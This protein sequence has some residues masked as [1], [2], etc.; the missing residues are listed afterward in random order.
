MLPSRLALALAL[1]PCVACNALVGIPGNETEARD[2]GTDTTSPGMIVFP[3]HDAATDRPSP[4]DG[5]SDAGKPSGAAVFVSS[6]SS[7]QNWC[8]VTAGGDVY[9]WGDNEAGQLGTSTGIAST[10]PVKITG[11]LEPAAQVSV[12]YFT[13]CALTTTGS[14]YCWGYGGD[15]ELGN[16]STTN[17]TATPVP[18]S[19]LTSGVVALS[20]GDLDACAIKEDGSVWCW[21]LGPGGV[22]GNGTMNDSLAPTEVVGLTGGATSVSVGVDAACAVVHGGVMC[23]GGES[24]YGDLGNGTLDES[25]TP[26]QVTGLTSG[27]TA[28]SVGQTFACALLD[29]GSVECWGEGDN[30]TLG[31]GQGANSPTPVMVT[32]LSSAVTA[33]S[34]GAET[35][36]ALEIGGGVVCWGGDVDGELGNGATTVGDAAD[37]PSVVPIKVKGLSSGVTA[38]STGQ[39]P[40]AITSSGGLD[41]WGLTAEIALT[42]TPVVANFSGTATAVTT[43]GSYVST[44]FACAL[45]DPGEAYCWGGNGSGQLGNDSTDESSIPVENQILINMATV[46]ASGPA[47]DFACGVASGIAYCWGDNS[48]GQLGNGSTTSSSMA[49]AVEGIPAGVDVAD[50]AVGYVSACALTTGGAVYCWGDNALGELGNNTTTSSSMALAV[51]GL[52]SGVTA[53]SVGLAYACAVLTDG[54]A[55]CWGNNENA[56][57]G[58]NSQTVS[59]VPTPVQGLTD[60]ATIA[61]GWYSTCAVTTAGAVECWGANLYDGLGN[62]DPATS[63]SLVPT[64]VSGLSSGATAVSVGPEATCAIV[65]GGV[66]CWG[67]QSLGNGSSQATPTP[68]PVSGFTSGATSLSVGTDSA[69]AVVA[70]AVECWGF[71]GAGQLGD[72]A[73]G[74]YLV[75]TPVPGFP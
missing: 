20:V 74:N 6:S 71:N 39:A 31:N 45:V 49:V 25:S 57:L 10:T 65:N 75:P 55:E 15:G 8:V 72:G 35:V 33:I 21:G 4:H 62:G 34:A 63:A 14:V 43:G 73:P 3:P 46:V 68:T 24:G 23:W 58:D 56:T 30:G 47:A 64:P 69:C 40:C 29:S 60:V 32:E 36:C 66:S 38:I 51:Q 53:I 5:P 52:S 42:P 37:T 41:C 26:V 2:A 59:K 61:A 28:V 27:V 17:T 67:W 1:V 9:C 54:T 11:L 13:I 16:G 70:G 19:G 50:V 44:A 18:V 22:L 48:K 12:G 7:A